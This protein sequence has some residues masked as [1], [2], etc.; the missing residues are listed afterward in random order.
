M[1]DY[2]GNLEDFL[3]GQSPTYMLPDLLEL[4]CALSHMLSLGVHYQSYCSQHP[5]FPSACSGNR[6]QQSSLTYTPRGF[7][8]SG[9]PISYLDDVCA[10]ICCWFCRWLLFQQAQDPQPTPADP[11]RD[12][13]SDRRLILPSHVSSH[14]GPA[15]LA[16]VRPPTAAGLQALYFR[17]WRRLL[18]VCGAS[19]ESISSPNNSQCVLEPVPFDPTSHRTK[20]VI[21]G[22]SL[23]VLH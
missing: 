11:P 13:S 22:M 5:V 7:P 19:S 9:R 8:S 20:A 14:T 2:I 4:G 10:F 3:A 6:R 15:S 16:A 18:Q 1:G 12:V 21:S 17:L 23:S